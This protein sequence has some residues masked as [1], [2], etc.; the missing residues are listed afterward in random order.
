MASFFAPDGQIAINGGEA[1]RGHAAI[2]GMAAGFF[3]DLPDMVVHC[4]DTR[5]AG[6]HA[7]LLWTFEGH[8]ARAGKFVRV[9]GW[10]D[11]ELDEAMKITASLGWFDSPD[12][13]RQIIEGFET[14][15]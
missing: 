3:A 7:I 2:A 12:Y 10:E 14:A 15:G 6:S 11:W 1:F 4:D 9:R 13:E 5:L 8:H